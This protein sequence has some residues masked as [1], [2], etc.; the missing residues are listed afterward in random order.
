[1]CEDLHLCHPSK[2]FR[3]AFSLW[4]AF[5][6]MTQRMQPLP[7]CQGRQPLRAQRRHVLCVCVC[8]YVCV[9]S[10]VAFLAPLSEFLLPRPGTSQRVTHTQYCPPAS[11]CRLGHVRLFIRG[12]YLSQAVLVC[13]SVCVCVCVCDSIPLCSPGKILCLLCLFLMACMQDVQTCIV[14]IQW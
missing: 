12:G 8:L 1:M 13:V 14:M 6:M 5:R 7:Q 11:R 2:I 3:H 10:Q 9:Y 4:R